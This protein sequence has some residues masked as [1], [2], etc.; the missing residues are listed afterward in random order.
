MIIINYVPTPNNQYLEQLELSQAKTEDLVK[1][2]LL[3][4]YKNIVLNLDVLTIAEMQDLNYKTRGKN[5]PTNVISIEYPIEDEYL[6]GDLF[7]CPEII[8]KEA[9]EQKKLI[10]NHCYHMIVHS[11]LHLQ[12]LDHITDADAQYMENLEISI[13]SEFGI[14]N[15]YHI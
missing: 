14:N 15:P 12:G 6:T 4:K 9:K 2:S 10:P 5:C 1:K 11:I 7:I 13:L 3:Q 8:I